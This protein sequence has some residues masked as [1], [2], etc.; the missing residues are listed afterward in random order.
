MSQRQPEGRSL[1]QPGNRRM[2]RVMD[3]GT[4]KVREGDRQ[5]EG[6]G[7]RK[8]EG[9]RRM[10]TCETVSSRDT[11]SSVSMSFAASSSFSFEES[12]VCISS[13]RA[14]AL[15]DARPA[16]SNSNLSLSFSA[17]SADCEASSSSNISR[18][19]SLP[20]FSTSLIERRD[21]DAVLLSALL[22]CPCNASSAPS[23]TLSETSCCSRSWLAFSPGETA[24][25]RAMR[26]AGELVDMGLI[27]ISASA[28]KLRTPERTG[29]GRR[30]SFSWR[31]LVLVEFSA[32]PIGSVSA[33][34]GAI[35]L[36]ANTSTDAL[37]FWGAMFSMSILFDIIERLSL[38]LLSLTLAGVIGD[39]ALFWSPPVALPKTWRLFGVIDSLLLAEGGS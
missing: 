23:S 34:S 15:S 19:C 21:D 5:G 24:H 20:R 12:I 6:G 36:P 8:R 32:S 13:S 25:P 9:W 7:V 18:I 30:S 26:P 37:A 31:G 11:R 35:T 16:S 39:D 17:R 29:E 28:S 4:K 33:P 14:A 3:A 10:H 2:V 22:S 27:L 38:S 1:R